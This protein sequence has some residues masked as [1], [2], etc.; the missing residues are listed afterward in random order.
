M[1]TNPPFANQHS[2]LV[3][4]LS[5][6]DPCMANMHCN[7]QNTLDFSQSLDC[8]SKLGAQPEH[9]LAHFHEPRDNFPRTTDEDMAGDEPDAPHISPETSTTKPHQRKKGSNP[10]VQRKKNRIAA[11]KCRRKQKQHVQALQER[12]SELESEHANLTSQVAVLKSEVLDLK[13]IIL[14][15]ANCD[16][17]AIQSYIHKAAKSLA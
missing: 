8:Y 2:A 3:Q 14:S 16:S 1:S 15:H 6:D 17:D 7:P 10:Q 12:E 5:L 9:G 4:Q 13:D 11:T